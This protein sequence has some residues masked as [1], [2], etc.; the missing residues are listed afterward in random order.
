ML[1]SRRFVLTMGKTIAFQKDAK[2]DP[3][4]KQK[5]GPVD[6]ELSWTTGQHVQSLSQRPVSQM[7]QHYNLRWR[8]PLRRETKTPF[9]S[10]SRK[11]PAY[12]LTLHL[13]RDWSHPKNKEICGKCKNSGVFSMFCWLHQ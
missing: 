1:P 8:M 6:A 2:K 4:A 3:A 12:Q 13:W 11:L 5:R 9:T 10:F 7:H